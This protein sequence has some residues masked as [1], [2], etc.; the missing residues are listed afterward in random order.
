[1]S[2]SDKI[3]LM[4]DGE[5]QQAGSPIELYSHPKNKFVAQFLGVPEM[6]IFESN[7][8]DKIIKIG[9]INISNINLPDQKLSL[10]IRPEDFKET[11]STKNSL[12]GTIKSIEYLGRDIIA[13]V[14]FE[15]HGFSKVFLRNKS[16]YDINEKLLIKIPKNKI[17]LFN[18]SKER[19]NV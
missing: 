6:K 14:D 18:S 16:K 17:H 8:E 10:G 5:I 19:I 4:S 11:T 15:I 1:M 3:I 12:K 9:N 13:K 7:L 2:I